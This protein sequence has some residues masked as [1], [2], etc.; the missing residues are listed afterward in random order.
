MRWGGPGK[1]GKTFAVPQARNPHLQLSI[2]L[3]FVQAVWP[4]RA[5]GRVGGAAV[6]AEEKDFVHENQAGSDRR[7]GR[8]GRVS[9]GTV[10]KAPDGRGQLRAQTRDRVLA[11][12]DRF[13]FRPSPLARGLLPMAPRPWTPSSA[14]RRTPSPHDQW[15]LVWLCRTSPA[16]TARRHGLPAQALVALADQPGTK[17]RRRRK[18]CRRRPSSRSGTCRIRSPGSP[19]APVADTHNGRHRL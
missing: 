8:P 13:G 7:C 3:L 17:I 19:R 15:L 11:V 6:L 10:S 5:L 16:A 4:L 2:P 9:I 18:R 12:A 14:S 1:Y